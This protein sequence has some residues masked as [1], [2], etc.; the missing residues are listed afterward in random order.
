MAE[1]VPGPDPEP[2]DGP[3]H[4]QRLGWTDSPIVAARHIAPLVAA[5]PSEGHWL[6]DLF[7]QFPVPRL[8]NG[9]SLNCGAGDLEFLALQRG[10]LA[11][12]DAFD[13]SYAAI[14]QARA[15]ALRDRF[16]TARF[17]VATAE[18]ALLPEATYD[19][20]LTQFGLHCLAD[21]DGF[22]ERLRRALRPGAWLI[23]N[24][25]VGPAH[26]QFDERQLRIV[27]ELCAVLPARLRRRAESGEVKQFHTPLPL[28]HFELHAPLEGASSRRILPALERG[29]EV[30]AR[31]DY[32]GSLL[33]PLLEGIVANFADAEESDRALLDLLAL[34]ERLLLREAGLPSD[35]AVLVARVREP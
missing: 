3:P 29:F 21:V 2:S 10:L 12:V 27:E 15:R 8:G 31:R 7:S 13:P 11:R 22:F 20:V 5:G 4:P 6:L 32:G 23:L 34:C 26:Y 30:V 9:L 19:F 33:N 17:E 14:E 1:T 24:E 28:A 16:E 25:Y 18:R 35:F